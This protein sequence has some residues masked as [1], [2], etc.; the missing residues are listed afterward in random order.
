LC[1]LF[2]ASVVSFFSIGRE[3]AAGQ[4]SAGQVIF[5]TVAAYSTSV[6]AGI[7]AAA[8]FKGFFFFTFHWRLPPPIKK[9]KLD[10]REGI[11]PD[12]NENAIR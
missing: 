1:E 3:A 8:V 2:E 9:I 7:G 11:L 6:T 4:L 12:I 5:Y 10:I